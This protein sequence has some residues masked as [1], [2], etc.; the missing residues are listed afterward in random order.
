MNLARSFTRAAAEFEVTSCGLYSCHVLQKRSE[1]FCG[2]NIFVGK[3]NGCAIAWFCDMD[4]NLQPLRYARHMAEVVEN[5]NEVVVEAI[6]P[7]KKMQFFCKNC[8]FFNICKKILKY[9]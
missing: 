1:Q 8:V 3:V 6:L 9:N 7:K 2:E 5:K 4:W